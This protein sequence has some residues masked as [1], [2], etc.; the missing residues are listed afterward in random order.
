MAVFGYAKE[1]IRSNVFYA[2]L[3][4]FVVASQEKRGK[5]EN[6]Q[7][8]KDYNQTLRCLD[9]ENSATLKCPLLNCVNVANDAC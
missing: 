3:K 8:R 5:R 1:S 4:D 6:T 7:A 2:W 9:K